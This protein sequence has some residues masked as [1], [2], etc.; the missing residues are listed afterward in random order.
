V[1][2]GRDGA[3]PGD[4]LNMLGNFGHPAIII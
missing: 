3:K 4:E 2:V 1:D